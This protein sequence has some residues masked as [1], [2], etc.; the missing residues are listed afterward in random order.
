MPSRKK[1]NSLKDLGPID[2]DYINI[3]SKGHH[4]S[5]TQLLATP[6]SSTAVNSNNQMTRVDSVVKLEIPH[7][8]CDGTNK[9]SL[10]L[11]EDYQSFPVQKMLTIEQD[12][13]L[14]H[15]DYAD[16]VFSWIQ[17]GK[18][19]LE[20]VLKVW[21]SVRKADLEWFY[22]YY[23]VKTFQFGPPH[24]QRYDLP[25][26]QVQCPD[27]KWLRSAFEVTGTCERLVNLFSGRETFMPHHCIVCDRKYEVKLR[28]TDD[29]P[30][31]DLTQDRRAHALVYHWY[32]VWENP[33]TCKCTIRLG[34]VKG[35]SFPNTYY[36][37]VTNTRTD[38]V[39]KMKELLA[40]GIQ[41]TMYCL[42]QCRGAKFTK[43]KAKITKSS[44]A[45]LTLCEMID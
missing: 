43:S 15:V 8:E 45:R 17:S 12:F 40:A 33:D 41:I 23:L 32:I 14:R 6:P 10:V 5:N 38:V 11:S 21:L 30:C 27:P 37:L 34:G 25:G 7:S 36:S 16:M 42:Y 4:K 24:S 13:N 22:Y 35:Q 29:Q 19:S 44:S 9:L 26:E 39:A 18:H 28:L 2:F 3:T 31:Y 1:K 20:D